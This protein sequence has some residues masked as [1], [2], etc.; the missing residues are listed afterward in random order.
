M[1]KKKRRYEIHSRVRVPD[2]DDIRKAASDFS[3]V[4]EEQKNDFVARNAKHFIST[5]DSNNLNPHLMDI[6]KEMVQLAMAVASEETA[7]QK[8]VDHDD[9]A[10]SEPVAETKNKTKNKRN[11]SP[12]I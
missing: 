6:K 1:D 7:E 3:E 12:G 2:F 11:I 4:S 10:V 8:K 5:D 9:T